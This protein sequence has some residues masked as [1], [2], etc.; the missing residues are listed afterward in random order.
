[1]RYHTHTQKNT[2]EYV[3]DSSNCIAMDSTTIESCVRGHHIYKAIWDPFEGEELVCH[4]E[5]NNSH[6]P[7]AV[8]V[9]KG[10]SIVGHVPRKISAACLLFLEKEDTTNTCTITGKRCYSSNLPQRGLQVPCILTFRGRAKNVGEI[11]KLL[12]PAT[13]AGL[14]PPPNKKR[15]IDN[16]TPNQ[17]GL[18]EHNKIELLNQEDKSIILDGKWLSDIHVNVAHQLLKKQFPNLSGL[19]SML[20]LSKLKNPIPAC[21]SALQILHIKGN[22]WIVTSTNGCQLGEVK[23]FDSLYRSIDTE[24]IALVSLI[25]GKDICDKVDIEQLMLVKC[26]G[27]FV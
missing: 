8:A 27:V 17:P 3:V 25:F 7:Y 10:D 19:F 20:L 18:D 1:M 11:V 22:H 24:T 2:L 4:K 16:I 9:M 15:K 26:V 6:D 14:H 12:C 23:L 5:E 21:E 13:G